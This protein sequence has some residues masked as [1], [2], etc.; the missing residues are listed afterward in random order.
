M[1]KP[2]PFGKIIRKLRVDKEVSL[3]QQALAFGVSSSFLS[4]IELGKK[5]INQKFIDKCVEYFGLDPVQ[6]TELIKVIGYS[7]PVVKIDLTDSSDEDRR[8]VSTFAY[9]YQS[10]SEAE[11]TKLQQ[12]LDEMEEKTDIEI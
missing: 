9:N 4:A 7:I 12:W 6:K 5:K 3:K 8:L 1:N 2:T 10:L 11:K